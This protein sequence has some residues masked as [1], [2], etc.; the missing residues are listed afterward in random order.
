MWLVYRSWAFIVFIA[1]PVAV[2]RGHEEA[3]VALERSI[4]ARVLSMQM[5]ACTVLSENFYGPQRVISLLTDAQFTTR[6]HGAR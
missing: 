6:G 3:S 5:I 1:K 4:Y 2:Y